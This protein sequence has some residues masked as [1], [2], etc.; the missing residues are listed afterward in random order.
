MQPAQPAGDPKPGLVEV[1]N[2]GRGDLAANQL[3]ETVQATGGA[4][5]HRGDRAA[6]DRRAEQLGQRLRGPVLGQK[7]GPRTGTR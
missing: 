2:L 4:G 5:G 1:R 7:T 3:Q 6:G